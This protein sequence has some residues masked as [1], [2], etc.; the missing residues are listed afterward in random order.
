MRVL[1]QLSLLDA[2]PEAGTCGEYQFEEFERKSPTR[3]G[4]RV[5]GLPSYEPTI[6]ARYQLL[7]SSGLSATL[8]ATYST[9][10]RPGRRTCQIS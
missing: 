1:T 7:S 9:K 3:R 2:A 4:T 8:G 10:R 6:Y 5:N